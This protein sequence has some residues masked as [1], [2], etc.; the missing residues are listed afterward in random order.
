MHRSVL[1]AVG[2]LEAVFPARIVATTERYAFENPE[3]ARLRPW[4]IPMARL[5]GVAFA[6]IATSDRASLRT[7]GKLVGPLGALMCLFPRQT[8]DVGLA[9]A[10]ENPGDIERKRWVVPATRTIGALYVV[11][12][13]VSGFGDGNPSRDDDRSDQRGDDVD[14]G[15]PGAEDTQ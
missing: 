11:I 5:E 12:A 9:T 3:D 6:W 10:Y 13:L 1:A 14:T 8:L 7:L 2:V 4:T 15:H